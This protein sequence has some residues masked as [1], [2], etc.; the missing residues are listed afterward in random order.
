[1][2]RRRIG[3]A[4]SLFVSG[5]IAAGTVGSA[6]TFASAE[7]AESS[8]TLPAV[9]LAENSSYVTD[10]Y[11]GVLHI[12]VSDGSV[13]RAS[14]DGKNRVVV[15][16]VG[17]GRAT[18]AYWYRQSDSA[19]WVAAS[20]PVSVSGAA[21]GSAAAGTADAGVVLPQKEVGLVPGG[22]YTAEGIRVNG[23]SRDARSFLWVSS[24]D[25]VAEVEKSTGKITAVSAGTATVYAVDPASKSCGFLSVTVS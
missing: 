2:K 25:A 5:L 17:A 22:V 13:V 14:A 3:I 4:L 10:S 6:G 19:G 8:V 1:M 11:S 23:V 7:S 18:V 16:G 24:S 20:L 9:T 21:G 15:T 12:S